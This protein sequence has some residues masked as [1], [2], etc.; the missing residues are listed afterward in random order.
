MDNKSQV[1]QNKEKIRKM[2]LTAVFT[3]IIFVM[4]NV[5]FLGYIGIGNISA[6]TLHIPVIIGA[7]LLGPKYGAFLGFAFGLSSFISS[8]FQPGITS[9]VFTPFAPIGHGNFWSLVI[10]FVPRILIGL[11]SYYVYEACV[12]LVKGSLARKEVP[13]LLAAGITG[14]LTNTILVLGGIYVFFG[15]QYAET[16]NIGGALYLVIMMIVL[17][18]GVPEAIVAAIL[19][20]AIG[21]VLL[22]VGRSQGIV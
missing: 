17:T 18:N 22:R 6:T 19:T 9:F 10:C 21:K 7:I 8:T 13:A 1:Y 4:A 12:K 11:V 14:S 5:P 2:V 3:A 20:L 16:L 15:A